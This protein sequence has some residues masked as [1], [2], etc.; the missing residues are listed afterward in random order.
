MDRGLRLV[1]QAVLRHFATT[2]RAP[3]P[4]LLEP[5][6]ARAGR[7]ADDVLTELHRE[8]VLTE[9]HREDVLT[10]DASGRNKA[11]YPFS[12]EETRH[13]VQLANGAG[14]WSMCAI[15]ALGI[16]ATPGRDVTVS[17]TDPVEG[18][19]GDGHLHQRRSH[20]GACRGG[21]MRYARPGAGIIATPGRLV[22]YRP[23]TGRP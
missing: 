14:V 18:P 10:L 12:A 6:A 9:L 5:F 4:E 15:D 7:T 1:Q 13:Q 3:D 8:D 23:T 21:R 17:S 20:V 19:P 2:G 22:E 16:P 11:A